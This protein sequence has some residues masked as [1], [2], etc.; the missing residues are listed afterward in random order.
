MKTI[1]WRHARR[2][3]VAVRALPLAAATRSDEHPALSYRVLCVSALIDDG[4]AFAEVTFAD[5]RE[6]E[7]LR[8]FW[9]TIHST[10]LLIGHELRKQLSFIV[11]RSFVNSVRPTRSLAGPWASRDD[12]IDTAELFNVWGGTP[13]VSLDELAAGLGVEDLGCATA[14]TYATRQA[15]STLAEVR[16]AYA[17]YS[18]VTF[19]LPAHSLRVATNVATEPPAAHADTDD[20]RPDFPWDVPPA[21]AE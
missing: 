10:D 20:G 3:F 7:L 15:D 12:L 1:Q 11:Q 2:V 19:Q 21:V 16:K 13:K 6:D 17:V 9:N 14:G 4:H 18:R 8:K 5:D